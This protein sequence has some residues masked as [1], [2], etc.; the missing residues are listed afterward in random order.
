MKLESVR[1]EEITELNNVKKM[2]QTDIKKRER[3]LLTLKF[4]IETDLLA[5]IRDNIVGL[6]IHF[7][8]N[9]GQTSNSLLLKDFTRLAPAFLRNELII[10]TLEKIVSLVDSHEVCPHE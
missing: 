8:E 3:L 6:R 4:I 10:D 7:Q 5:K 2:I 9:R 1:Q